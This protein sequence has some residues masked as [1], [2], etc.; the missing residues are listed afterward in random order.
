MTSFKIHCQAYIRDLEEKVKAYDET[1]TSSSESMIDLKREITR[2]RDTESHSSQ[3][4]A[5]LEARLARSDESIIALQQ[6]VESLEKDSHR[7][8]DEVETLQSRL[9]SLT[10][11]GQGWREDLAERELK[12]KDLELKMQEWESKKKEAGEER[13]RLGEIVDQVATA[14][15]SLQ[16]NLPVNGNGISLPESPASSPGPMTPTESAVETQLVSL[17]QTHTATLADLSSI[18]SKYRDALREIHDLSSQLEEMKLVSSTTTSDFPERSSST[19]APIFTRRKPARNGSESQKRLFFRQ[20]A[21]AESLHSR[22][23]N[24]SA[25]T[26]NV[27][28]DHFAQVAIAIAIAFTGAFIG[29]VAQNL[30]LKSREHQ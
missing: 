7:R 21:S 11:D 27:V 12:V 8:R 15:R 22:Y 23:D 26:I 28:S 5:D 25:A 16:L 30:Y 9:E 13:L 14:R 24:Q 17:Q 19:E 10:R 29:Q 20:A 3:Y 4:I 18:T 2:Y 6:T 1:N